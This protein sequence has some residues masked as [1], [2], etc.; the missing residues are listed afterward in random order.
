MMSEYTSPGNAK[1]I[2]AQFEELAQKRRATRHFLQ[3]PLEHELI[4]R[5]LR[6]AQWAPSGYKLQPTRLLSLPIP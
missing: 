1:P 6:T 2:V 5:L 4:E 3:Q